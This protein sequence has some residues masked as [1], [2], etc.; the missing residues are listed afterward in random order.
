VDYPALTLQRYNSFRVAAG[1][2]RV[3]AEPFLCRG[4]QAHADYLLRNLD[5]AAVQG[6]GSRTEDPALPGYTDEGKAAAAHATIA[7]NPP[8]PPAALDVWMATLFFRLYLLNPEIRRIGLGL[9]RHP[10]RGWICVLDV[11]RGRGSDEIV[12]YPIDGQTHVPVAF[13]G[14]E[15]PNPIPE[16]TVDRAG[17]PVTV[18]FPRSFSVK[19]AVAVLKDASGREVDAWVSTPEKPAYKTEYQANTV[20]LFAKEVLRPTTAYAVKVTATVNKRAWTRTWT[21]TTADDDK[22]TQPSRHPS[23]L[24]QLNAYRKIVGQEPVTLDRA[25]SRGC[26]LHAEYVLKNADHPSVAGLGVHNEDPSLPGYTPEGARAGKASV[27]WRWSSR[28]LASASLG[29]SAPAMAVDTWMHTFFHRLPLIDPDLKRIGFGLAHREEDHAA[30]VVVVMDVASA[31]GHD[32][33]IFC[34]ADGQKDVALAY[35]PRE[36]PSPIPQS[37]DKKAGYPITVT[38]PARVTV[39]DVEADLADDRGQVPTWRSTPTA[40]VSPGLQGNTVALIAQAPL[41]PDTTYTVTLRAR[42][43]GQAWSRTL[44]FTTRS[45][46]AAVRFEGMRLMALPPQQATRPATWPLPFPGRPR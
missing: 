1:L 10:Q 34:P 11:Y 43:D 31:R 3:T 17:Y 9:A 42:L 28:G 22:T 19:N 13:P 25:I 44:R 32:T 15:S 36:L 26:S 30:W 6:A 4:C 18:T 40:N 16:A 45:A 5:H 21:F 37:K 14:H 12:I 38:F 39:R 33:P 23:A 46:S 20:C 24:A 27:I 41:K 29:K 8:N 7:F 35:Q 2:P